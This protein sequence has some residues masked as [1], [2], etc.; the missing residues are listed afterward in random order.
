MGHD[1]WKEVS[2][3][4]P[5]VLPH[6]TSLLVV[7]RTQRRCC[8]RLRGTKI[9]T[10]NDSVPCVISLKEST[11]PPDSCSG[12]AQ[13]KAAQMRSLTQSIFTE[14]QL[15]RKRCACWGHRAQ[16]HTSGNTFSGRGK[17]TGII[18]DKR[19]FTY[20]I[21]DKGTFESSSEPQTALGG[22]A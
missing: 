15:H 8:A 7:R 19:T 22:E 4:S 16:S 14:E 20:I 2:I 10:K 1:T 11:F 3:P 9:S 17:H 6:K 21:L 5:H 18:L 12:R 13:Q